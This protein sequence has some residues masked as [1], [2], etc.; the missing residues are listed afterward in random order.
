MQEIFAVLDRYWPVLVTTIL[1]IAVSYA[2]RWKQLSIYTSSLDIG[3][4]QHMRLYCARAIVDV[5]VRGDLGPKFLEIETRSIFKTKKV[6]ATVYV[7]SEG[8]VIVA[9][10]DGVVA[11]DKSGVRRP[12][13]TLSE[14]VLKGITIE[15]SFKPGIFNRITIKD[16]TF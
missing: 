10:Q 5:F 15:R 14:G 2:A 6:I 3:R 7:T 4:G 9:P 16:S 13:I 12:R 1:L 8:R 11:F